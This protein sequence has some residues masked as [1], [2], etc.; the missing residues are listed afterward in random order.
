MQVQIVS[1][2]A[3]L[4]GRPSIVWLG[5]VSAEDLGLDPVALT[6]EAA[7]GTVNEQLFRFFNRV[8]EPDVDRLEALGF[9]LPSLSVGDLLHWGSK[10]WRVAGAGF[11]QI[12]DS[13]EYVMALTAYTLKTMGGEG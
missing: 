2:Q 1:I 9:D 8:D 11:E 12:T 7:E 4:H 13:A 5:D 3:A 10:T 6:H